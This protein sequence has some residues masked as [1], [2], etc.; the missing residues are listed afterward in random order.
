MF[1]DLKLSG[2]N[3]LI[4]GSTRGIGYATSKLLLKEGAHVYINGRKK[5]TVLEAV[6]NLKLAIPGAQVSPFVVDFNELSEIENKLQEIPSIDILIN[7]VGIYT[8]KSFYATTLADW[9]SQLQVNVIGSVELAKRFLPSMLKKNWGRILFISSECAYIVPTDMIS[10]SATKAA[11]HAISKGLSHL[12]RGT[13]VTVNTIVPGS[14]YT[15]GA[16]KFIEE[17][18]VLEGKS[19]KE[20]E[21]LF[22]LNERPNSLLER[23]ASVDEVASTIT[24]FCSPLSGATNGSVIKVDGGSSGGIL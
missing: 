18:A 7:N 11:L 14:T 1:M 24:Y 19:P 12:T 5:E 10:Y 6:E 21:R 2:K 3:I 4:T 22:F 8:S 17:K 16:K 13:G 20:T 9:N 15:E 23:F